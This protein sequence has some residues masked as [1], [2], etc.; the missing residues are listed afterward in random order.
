M[1]AEVKTYPGLFDVK[2]FRKS[3]EASDKPL[4]VFKEALQAG[5]EFLDESFMAGEPIEGLVNGR[6]WLVDQLLIHAWSQ[7]VTTDNLALVAV[8]GYGRGELHPC[9]DIDLMILK[10]PRLRSSS[11]IPVEKYLT[12][13]W[14]MGLEVGH[15][16]RSVRECIREAK[17][18]ITVATNLIE[19]RLIAGNQDLYNDMCNLTGPGKIWP[20]KKFFQVKLE[21]QQARHKKY[22]GS[23]HKLEPNI[24]ECPGGMRDIQMIGWVAK[25]HFRT[26]TL[27]ELIDHNFLTREEW[28]ILHTGQS[29]LWRIRYGLHLIT[30]R[31]E[32][33]LLF[34]HQRAVAEQFGFRT[35]DNSGVEQFMKMYY[36]T[37]RELNMLNEMLLQHFQEVIIYARRREKIKPLNNRFQI[38]N[39]F[40]EVRN[41]NVFSR[42]PFAL[43]EIFLLK[44]QNPEIKGVR[45]STIRL[46]RQNADRINKK[47]RDDLRNRALFMEII[48]QPRQVGH[49]LRRMHRYGLLSRYL[50]A[51]DKIEGLMQFDLF[52]VYTVDEHILF[53]VKNLRLMGIEDGQD[54][55]SYH[56][57][58]SLLPKQ[59]ILYLAGLFHDIAK[60]RGGDHSELGSNEAYRFCKHHSMSEYDAK[61]VAWLVEKHLY[62]SKTAQR[63]D[64]SDPEVINT[65]AETVADQNHLNYLYLLTVGDIKAT[66]PD[67][68]N[69]WKEGLL[70][71]L[72]QKALLALRRGLEHPINKRALISDTKKESVGLLGPRI[73]AKDD[74]KKFWKQLGEDYF[75]RYSADEIAWHYNSLYKDIASKTPKVL[76]REKSARGGSELFVYMK[77]RD[78]IFSTTTQVLDRL[79]LNVVDA[80]I[81][82][83]KNDYVFDSYIILEQSGEEVSG[84]ERINEIIEKT[85]TALTSRNKLPPRT[86]RRRSRKLDHFNV[87]TRVSFTEDENNNRNIMEVTTLDQ[88]GLLSKIG[89]AMD[90][91]GVRLQGAKIA[92]Y[93]ARAEDIFFIT[94]REN[95]LIKDPLKFECLTHSIESH[96]AKSNAAA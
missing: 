8:G 82:T 2:G 54:N 63:M 96:L 7:F 39:D 41:K 3:L 1:H 51:F 75:L 69:N 31:R 93:G 47:F 21:E 70:A 37:V 94:D 55:A 88:P 72:Y 32:D 15:S 65:F 52:H 13:L 5:H 81:I 30:R 38:R 77:N 95:N 50:P 71:E 57:I 84:K 9:S 61:L 17:L 58:H 11:L 86:H 35:S 92:T 16:V 78:G 19:S 68:W 87:P 33:R 48:K 91:C 44:Q 83:S 20:T 45:A 25:R 85:R 4:I 14:D 34:D 29:L 26:K 23:E 49:E 10:K 66:N 79:G 90:F 74:Y 89:M 42:Y 76:V 36:R 40:L 18:D 43:L 12:F 60:G 22:D 62:M 59:E 6:A 53:V 46:I 56:I 67:L 24:K 80:R 27:R 64:I 73:T 28:N